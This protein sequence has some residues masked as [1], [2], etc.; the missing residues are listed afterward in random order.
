MMIVIAVA[1]TGGYGTLLVYLPP[2]F[3][4]PLVLV[5]VVA[6]FMVGGKLG[7][8]SELTDIGVGY[9]RFVTKS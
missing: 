9:G 6:A 8:A 4:L 2:R 1:L 3:R 5:T 7:R